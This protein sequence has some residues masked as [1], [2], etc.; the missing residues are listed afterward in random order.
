MRYWWAHLT[1]YV[2]VVAEGVNPERLLNL[3]LHRGLTLWDVRRIGRERLVFKAR[4]Q[5]FFALRHVARRA[6]CRLRLLRK[7]GCPFL[8]GRLR[9]RPAFLAGLLFFILALYLAGSFVWKVETRFAAPPRYHRE[10]EVLALAASLGLRPGAWRPGLVANDLARELARRLPR[11]SWVGVR[12]DGVRATIE[13]VELVLPERPP[14]AAHLV[15]ARDGVVED[16]LVFQGTP[17]VKRGDVVRRGQVLISGIVPGAGG[18]GAQLVRAQGVVRARVWY[19]VYATAPLLERREKATGREATAYFLVGD[20]RRWRLWGPETPPFRLWRREE[21]SWTLAWGQVRLP[22]ALVAVAWQEVTVEEIRHSPV[23]AE[24]LA[25]AR[26]E[27]ALGARVAAEA[28]VLSRRTERV[29]SGAGEVK[30]RAVAETLEDIGQL[31]PL[32]SNL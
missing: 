32:E 19:E 8:W 17:R 27:E 18:E 26:A 25:R 11:A 15:A 13:V 31:Y 3:A 2:L 20:G 4:A 12:L 5:D 28:R 23:Q 7:R 16:V 29:Y 24:A 30:V 9:R 14:R 10:E 6:G 22:L 1:G 21:R